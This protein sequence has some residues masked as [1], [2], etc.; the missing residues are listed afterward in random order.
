MSR[1]TNFF[2]GIRVDATSPPPYL[3]R[4]RSSNFFIITTICIAVFSDIFLYGIIVPV[5]PFALESRV[6]V[7][8]SS[9]QSYV[10]IL[11]AVY[12]AALLVGSPVAGWYADNSSS[13]RLPLLAGLL[14]L[15]GATVMLCFARTVALLV[16]GRILQGLSAAIVWTVGL[17]LLV[18]TVGQKDIGQ[19]VGYVSISM[20][21]G[22]LLAPL[23]GGIVY[24]KAGYYP[25]FYMAFALLAL[26]IILRMVLIEKKIARQWLD[27]DVDEST[28]VSLP[29]AEPHD[30]EKIGESTVV[31]S[32]AVISGNTVLGSVP[33]TTDVE[34]HPGARITPSEIP[35][36]PIAKPS[37][38]PPIVT[39]LRSRR[40]VAALWAWI[41]Q[42]SLMT[43]FDSVIPLYV[44]D[45]FHVRTNPLLFPSASC[46]SALMTCF[47]LSVPSFRSTK[48]IPLTFISG[49]PSAPASSF[50]PS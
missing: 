26:D 9:T 47:S 38:W 44:K 10:S 41:V 37:K 6:D 29:S 34:S 8:P 1:I 45:T 31:V 49:T 43:A 3:L 5:I 14:A 25:V 20:S 19:I 46:I 21:L 36:P 39:L 7:A 27:D 33:E 22:V 24:E 11:L 15:L 35:P 50:S 42:G 32:N 28:Q 40:L 23:L 2:S 17:A 30:A 48:R 12:G 18:D 16:V 13:R 4:Y